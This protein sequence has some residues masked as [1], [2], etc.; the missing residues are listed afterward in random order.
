MHRPIHLNIPISK[1]D[2]E[3]RMAW[4]IATTEDIDSQG[5]IVDYEASK[6]AFS[7][8]LG[9]IR[10]MHQPI[11][12]GKAIDIQYDD[13]E[14][15]VAIGVKLSEST[16]GENAWIKVKEGV[17]TGFSIGGSVNKV[18][19]EV[20]KTETG[21]KTVTRLMDYSLA[22]VSLVDNPANP[23]AQLVMVK[24]IDGNLQRV[25]VAERVADPH[26]VEFWRTQFMLPIEKAQALYDNSMK[27]GEQM[28]KAQE[29]KKGLWSASFLLD[30]ACDLSYYIQ[31]E[32]YE[33]ENVDDLNAALATIKQAIVDELTEPDEALGDAVELAERVTNLKKG[34]AMSTETKKTTA[35]IGEDERDENAEVVA[36]PADQP[37]KVEEPKADDAKATETAPATDKKEETKVP[38][39]T[40]DAGAEADK[41]A[42]T[43]AADAE[44]ESSEGAEDPAKAVTLGDLSKFAEGLVTK[45]GDSQKESVTK[46][47]GELAGKVDEQFALLK[48]RLE[49]LEDQPADPKIKSSFTEVKKGEENAAAGEG[50]VLEMTKRRDELAADPNLGTPEERFELAAK[51]RKAQAAGHKIS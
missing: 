6:S 11:A 16:D 31:G 43:P 27:K 48:G 17:L 20:V 41:G 46:V 9:N 13:T 51:L 30:L 23:K 33:G 47:I 50:D 32:Q 28:S 35:V 7:Q 1:I 49:K 37:A 2:E 18:K 24:S 34:K 40:E 14:K 44:G 29:V 25:E 4:G 3:Q 5:D 12:V 39:K 38:V 26:P 10:E 42:A 8:W 21:E 15:V 36:A 19:K 45:L 22:E